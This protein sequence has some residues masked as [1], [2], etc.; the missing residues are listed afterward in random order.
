MSSHSAIVREIRTG[1]EALAVPADAPA[2]QQYMKSEMPFRG[3]RFPGVRRLC[4]TVFTSHRLE[5]RAEWEA[6]VRELFDNATHREERYAALGL[7]GHRYYRDWLTAE[8]LPLLQHVIATGAWWDLV[9]DASHRVGDVLLA[10]RVCAE[11]VIR[12]WQTHESLWLRRSSIICQLG[13]RDSTDSA[14]MT[15]AIV[16]NLDDRD[17]FIRKAIGWALREYGKSEPAW[18][19]DFVTTYVDRLSPLSKRE[20]LKHLA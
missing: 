8:T 5:D 20:A 17:F 2:M 3:V 15:D 19:L 11:L 12:S 6:T 9:D 10:D 7:I 16:A 18:V 4:R 13:H 1:L 14:L